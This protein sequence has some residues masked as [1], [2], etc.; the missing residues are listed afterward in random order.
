MNRQNGIIFGK[1]I[2]KALAETKVRLLPA[3]K[4]IATNL[5]Y[6][7]VQLW[8]SNSPEDHENDTETSFIRDGANMT[9]NT[10]NSYMAGVY[11]DGVFQDV[12]YAYDVGVTEKPTADYSYPGDQIYVWHQ[13]YNTADP[14]GRVTTVENGGL[15]VIR[16]YKKKS[17]KFQKVGRSSGIKD[18]LNYLREQRPKGMVSFI[19]VVGVPYAKWLENVRKLK[20]L[21]EN[22]DK[23]N[24]KAFAD[25]VF[26]SVRIDFK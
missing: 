13:A 21:T 25:P 12:V 15:N 20:V 2:A 1:G 24:V 26:K 6:D 18:A 3:F 8:E 4:R 5:L 19:I 7:A 14:S 11:K 10:I 16:E 17:L 22:G 23:N 9:G